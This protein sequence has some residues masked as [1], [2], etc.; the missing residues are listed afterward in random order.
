LFARTRVGEHFF[1]K[2]LRANRACYNSENLS[3]YRAPSRGR[4]HFQPLEGARY[5]DT[6][7][8]SRSSL[9][10]EKN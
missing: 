8:V 4:E 6:S 3:P 1:P 5:S 2:E 10:R 9:E 7:S